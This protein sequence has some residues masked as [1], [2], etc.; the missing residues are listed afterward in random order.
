MPWD[1]T[2]GFHTRERASLWL[3]HL[4]VGRVEYVQ[5][6]AGIRICLLLLFVEYVQWVDCTYFGDESQ[7]KA[8][9]AKRT[10]I[11]K[12]ITEQI[13]ISIVKATSIKHRF[14]KLGY[15]IVIVSRYLVFKYP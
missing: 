3:P 13:Q 2:F 15:L 14:T 9:L 4:S 8:D 6:R 7:I 11:N 5:I 10:S 1:G 12:P